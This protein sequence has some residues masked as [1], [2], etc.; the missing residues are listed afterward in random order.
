[1]GKQMKENYAETMKA[2]FR[3]EAH[4]LLIELET[5]LLELETNSTDQE[6][7]GRVF[8]ALHTIKGSGAMFG[9]E[10]ISEF[11]H[12]VETVFDQVR[13]GALSASKELIDL[14]LSARDQILAMLDSPE[15]KAETTGLKNIEI[16]TLLKKLTAGGST[17]ML[18]DAAEA[19]QAEALKAKAEQPS[20][21]SEENY[22]IHFRPS[23]DIF[24]HGTNPI[25]LI[26]ELRR[27]GEC[28]ILAHTGTIPE[29]KSLDPEKCYTA[30]HILLT[31]NKG[32]NS[33]KDVFIFVEDDSEL[34]IEI[35]EEEK[36][37]GIDNEPKKLG[38]M[39]VERG[40]LAPE[41]LDQI[42]EEK[43]PIGEILVDAG[44]VTTE[45]V[46]L[47][48]VEQQHI[49]ETQEK[50]QSIERAASIRVASDKLD[51]LVDLVGEM[52][53]VQARLSQTTSQVENA[54]LLAIAEEVERLTAELR[55]T[56]MSMRMVPIGTT[57]NKFR[58][59]IRDLSGKLGKDVTLT[60]EG[61]DTELDKT[62]IE[63]LNDPMIHLIRNCMDHGI[64]M[65]AEREKLGKAPTGTIHLR[66]AHSGAYVLIEIFDDGGGLNREKI[67]AKAVEKGLATR[68]NE[69]SDKE[70]YNLL[71]APGFSTAE[72]VTDLSGRGVGMDVV[73]RIIDSLGGNI[74]IN[75]IKDKGTTITLKIPLTLAIIEGLLVELGGDFFVIPLSSI[76]E[77]VELSREDAAS[78]HG[79]HLAKVRGSLLPYI[80]LRQMF[81]IGGEV[82]EIQQIVVV[83]SDGRKVGFLVDKVIGQ[84]QTVIKS[85]GKTYRNIEGVS[86]ATILGDGTVALI[87][88]VLKLTEKA[89]IEEKASIQ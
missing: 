44:L 82:P 31:T 78:S 58:R 62:V 59:L 10:K 7:I 87:L 57:F 46:E 88:D 45:K 13:E 39:L 35:I 12:E 63:R 36:K 72:K 53:T 48:L 60:T 77:C 54:V 9:F 52:V 6:L 51:S 4:E 76:E 71:F 74:E 67:L 55:D 26:D 33:I 40:D 23:P 16:I 32:V 21:E 47:A 61:A 73:K 15:E 22:R 25:L 69:L 83:F 8:R 20:P 24:L 27:L 49:K 5:A 19:P 68:E 11:T 38:E 81:N 34:S 56:A 84:L 30:W 65:P 1:M 37:P 85:L 66:A 17:E 28:H 89:E 42:L 3:E 14:T 64:E 41:K 80:P 86:G 79:R 70:I 2:A 18:Q 75:S 43:K 50:R 29:L